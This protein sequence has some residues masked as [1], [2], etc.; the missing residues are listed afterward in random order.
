MYLYAMI[1]V[2]HSFCDFGS[3]LNIN[4]HSSGESVSHVVE[5]IYNFQFVSIHCDICLFTVFQVLAD[6]QHLSFILLIVRS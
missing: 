2:S 6:V 5:F 1:H 3:D 4:V